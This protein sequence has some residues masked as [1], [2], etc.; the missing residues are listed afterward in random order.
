MEG[1]MKRVLGIFLGATLALGAGC[2]EDDEAIKSSSFTADYDLG[3]YVKGAGNVTDVTKQYIALDGKITQVDNLSA[4]ATTSA[5]SGVCEIDPDLQVTEIAQDVST[6]TSVRIAGAQKAWLLPRTYNTA[7]N[8]E[9]GNGVHVWGDP[10]GGDL[11]FNEPNLDIWLNT[12]ASAECNCKLDQYLSATPVNLHIFETE[13]DEKTTRVVTTKSADYNET[14]TTINEYDAKT[15]GDY[16][17]FV[18]DGYVWETG[19]VGIGAGNFYSANSVAYTASM[20]LPDN[21]AVGD[22]WLGADGVLAAAVGIES[23]VIGGKRVRAL[24][25]VYRGS[26]DVTKVAQS[27]DECVEVIT[28]REE[29]ND[30]VIT[31]A[32]QAALKPACYTGNNQA[33]GWINKRHVWYY[34][35]L[36][37]KE[38]TEEVTLTINRYGFVAGN[39]G[40]LPGA[41]VAVGDCQTYTSASDV[42][43]SPTVTSAADEADVLDRLQTFIEYSVTNSKTTWE[44]TEIRDNYTIVTEFKENN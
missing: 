21:V 43:N 19:S 25:V 8:Q 40:N 4:T 18:L 17:R 16:T 14:E 38:E 20:I 33:S 44:A 23:L 6:V 31:V 1:N 37:V 5:T 10:S 29:D 42:A 27:A 9:A 36:P 39:D 3:L 13:R 28:S 2:S 15:I 11:F 41:T 35:G 22:T 12:Q 30:G 34:K 32:K 24:H 26:T 7:N